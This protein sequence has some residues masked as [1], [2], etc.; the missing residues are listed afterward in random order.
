M[1][2]APAPM[3]AWV[4]APPPYQASIVYAFGGRAPGTASAIVADW[5]IAIVVVVAVPR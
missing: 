3:N 2:K 4:L 5:L 1:V